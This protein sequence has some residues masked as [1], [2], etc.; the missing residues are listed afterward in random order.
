MKADGQEGPLNGLRVIDAASLLAAPMVGTIMADFGADVIKVE[1][2]AGDNL[3]RM[4]VHKNG[5]PLWWKVHARNKRS[6][7]LDFHTEKGKEILKRLVKDADVI[8][9]NFRPGRL[10]S[11]G[12]GYEDLS[13]VNPRIIMVRVSGFGQTGPYRSRPGFGSLAE[14]M[15]GCAYITGDPSGPPIL[16]PFGLA[17]A[18]AAQYAL[19]ATMFAIYERDVR[20]SG[21]GQ[22]IDVALYEPLFAILGYQS[23]LYDQLGVIQERTGSRSIH[24]APRNIYK[25]KDDHWVAI[26]TNTPSIV[27]RVMRLTGGDAFADDPRFQTGPDRVKHVDEIDAVVGGWIGKRTLKEVV[28]TFETAEGA[29]A[30]VYNIAQI[31]E[32]PQFK[33][34]E[35]ITSVDDPELGRFKLQNTFPTLSRTPGK[36]RH[37]GPAKGQHTNEILGGELGLSDAEIEELRAQKVI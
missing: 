30:P 16:P 12:L 37:S 3:R 23:T 4:G 25:T 18:V 21:K 31:F 29:V 27:D 26:S 11:W 13:K 24:S 17:D 28:D 10:E 7:T 19:F 14:A 5:I 22:M 20:G 32:D 35:S 6:I 1:H 2:P 33:A 36:I 34:R 8:L 9:E 15:S